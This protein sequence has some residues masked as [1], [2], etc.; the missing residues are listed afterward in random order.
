VFPPQF[1]NGISPEAKALIRQLLVIDPERR[2]SVEDA[3][4]S[5]WIKKDE[6]WLKQKYR[7]TVLGHWI[8]TSQHL[9]GITRSLE[10]DPT[11]NGA[12]KR[13]RSEQA[14]DSRSGE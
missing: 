5:E 11:E 10:P 9:G 8:K 12:R 4:S 6:V 1:W 14:I 2:W 7:V 13:A 3:L